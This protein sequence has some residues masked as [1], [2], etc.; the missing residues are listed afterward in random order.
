MCTCG[1]CVVEQQLDR[2]DG[3][4]DSLV[5]DD[6]PNVAGRMQC[7]NLEFERR[8]RLYLQR[9]FERVDGDSV[10]YAILCDGV[11]LAREYSDAMQVRA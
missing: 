11:R 10:L 5:M 4:V 2:D 6:L 3:P 1:E 8:C 7:S 9:E